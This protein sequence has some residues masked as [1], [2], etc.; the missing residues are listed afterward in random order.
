MSDAPGLMRRVDDTGVPLLIARLII[1][2]LFVYMGLVKAADPVEF[3]KLI[4]EYEMVPAGAWWMMNVMAA[5]LPWVEVA[6]GVL[7][8]A[9]VALRGTASVALAMLVVFTA[10][11]AARAIGVY[12]AGGI[13]FCDIQFDCGCGAGVV[14][15]CTKLPENV[16]LSLL[17]IVVLLSRSRRFCLRGDLIPTRPRVSTYP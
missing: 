1:G 15:I 4:R 13:A 3:M 16:A 14:Y 10:A 17:A 6:C 7:M 8:V 5:L 2:G 11:I 12:H 9:G